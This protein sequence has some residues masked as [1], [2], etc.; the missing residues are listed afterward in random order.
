MIYQASRFIP[1]NPPPAHVLEEAIKKTAEFYPRTVVPKGF[2]GPLAIITRLQVRECFH[3]MNKD[4][5]AGYPYSF[6][7][8]KKGQW[9][10]RD[11]E[12]LIDLVLIRLQLLEETDPKVVGQLMPE[13]LVDQGFV[14][15]VAVFVKNDPHPM[16]KIVE[17]RYRIIS[18]CSLVD[19]C[20]KRLLY[21]EQ[22]NADKDEC[23]EPNGSSGGWDWTTDE[24]AAR[25]YKSVEPWLDEAATSDVSAW[26]WS[27]AAW[28]FDAEL[29]IRKILNGASDVGSWSKIT[30]NLT[31]CFGKSVY[32]LSDGDA[33]ILQNDGV[34]KSGDLNTTSG[35]GRMRNMISV[36]VGRGQTKN[37]KSAGDDNLSTFVDGSVEEALKYGIRLT[38]YKKIENKEEGFEFCSNIFTPTRAI[39][40][41]CVKSLY[42]LLS[43]KP[44]PELLEVFYREFRHA[45]DIYDARVAISYS[46]YESYYAPV[47]GAK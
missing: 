9:I 23:Y 8:A 35:N 18:N 24:A 36:L 11:V 41:T 29:K 32:V 33:L 37:T 47:G 17:G 16:R 19:E 12:T 43:S 30:A 7:H 10:D 3:Q 45:P 15:P 44:D 5:V 31:M 14:D 28:M 4:A 38:D 22:N 34:Q 21:T 2:E 20:V 26:D 13:E 6:V 42:K 27:I 1:T 46:G 39:P 40:L 25:C